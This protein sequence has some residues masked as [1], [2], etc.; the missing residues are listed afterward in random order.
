MGV[1]VLVGT[2]KGGFLFRS[3]DSRQSWSIS[4]PFFK[5]WKVTT[6]GR[7]SDGQYI[8]GTASQVYGAAIHKSADLE[9]WRQVEKGPVY[10]E[11]SGRKLNQIWKLV[12]A[13]GVDYA[14]V[15]EAGLFRSAD[16]GETWEP[17]SALNDHHTRGSWFP[18]AGGLC[19]HS[20]L[21]DPTNDQRLWCG[22]SA[23]G[24][25][26]T[27]D[28]GATWNEKNEGVPVII[29][30]KEH[31]GIGFCVHGLVPDPENPDRIY[32]QDH[33]G[34]YRSSNG[35]DSW[36]KIEN[37]LPSR[38][39]F[40]IAMGRETKTLY[41]FPLESDEYRIPTDGK[42]RVFRSRDEG[43]SWE[44]L[45]NGLPQENAYQ[46][47]LR[48]AM[49]TDDLDPCGVYVGSTSGTVHFSNDGGDSWQTLPCTFPRI[50]TVRVFRED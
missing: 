13:A 3:D 38:F 9:E 33:M 49:D 26:R 48:G 20:I 18:G 2:A 5:G 11:E 12:S 50:L 14:G 29:E 42:F 27:D 8:A 44:P 10:A 7:A 40:P 30:D 19:A 21:A 28:G 46:G 15:D 31:K 16:G 23:V 47:V 35:G 36:E 17:V 37:G 25:F 4:G 45:T 43:E 6:A 34:M 24:V 39:G 32:R 1:V 41:A 22:I